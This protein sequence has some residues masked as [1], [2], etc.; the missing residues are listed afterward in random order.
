M[1]VTRLL[2]VPT[3]RWRI[4]WPF[5]GEAR[6]ARAGQRIHAVL[7]GQR[8]TICGLTPRRISGR[9]YTLTGSLLLVSSGEGCAVCRRDFVRHCRAISGMEV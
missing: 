6:R 4:A 9:E 5:E 2:K 1:Q 8:T 3:D 7:N